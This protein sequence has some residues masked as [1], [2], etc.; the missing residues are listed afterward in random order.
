MLHRND[1]I[2]LIIWPVA[3]I[4]G[5]LLTY[6]FSDVVHLWSIAVA[7]LVVCGIWQ[8]SSLRFVARASLR[9]KMSNAWITQYL[10]L[11]VRRLLM[12]LV[13]SLVIF[14]SRRNEWGLPYWLSVAAYYQVGLF[15]T[16]REFWQ[17][18]TRTEPTSTGPDTHA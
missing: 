9:S 14:L 10:R 11:S 12:T 4:L 17:L 5:L 6:T 18:A 16:V 15:L 7:W 13:V 2:A 1:W 8:I 3:L